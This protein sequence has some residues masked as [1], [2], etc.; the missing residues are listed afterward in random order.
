MLK[1]FMFM[2]VIHILC[3]CGMFGPIF[4]IS[5]HLHLGIFFTNH[6]ICLHIKGVTGSLPTCHIWFFLLDFWPL[7]FMKLYV[8]IYM[9][10]IHIKI[11]I[12]KNMF[13]FIIWSIS[14]LSEFSPFLLS[15]SH[16]VVS[17][18][19]NPI[20]GSTPGFPVLHFLSI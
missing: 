16:S 14:V 7:F 18:L 19:C 4:C 12:H 8:H 20:N 15:F 5:I 9:H 3:V 17:V 1:F 13:S 10:N 2:L 11:L 6:L